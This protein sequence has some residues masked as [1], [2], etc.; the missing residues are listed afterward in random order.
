[1]ANSRKSPLPNKAVADL[2]DRFERALEAI[3]ARVVVSGDGALAVAC[4]GGLD[5]ALL[6]R[7]TAD[8]CRRTQRPLQVFHVH[9]G[10]SP[11]ADDWLSHCEA[12]AA[13]LGAGFDAVRVV[14]RDTRGDGIEQAAR[15]ARYDALGALCRRHG[16]KLLLTAH[17]QDDQAETVLLQLFRGA[18]LRG[19]S[20][21]AAMQ[22]APTLAGSGILLGRPLLDCRRAELEAVAV[23]LGVRHVVDESNADTRFR[24]NAVRHVILPVIARHFPAAGATIA[25]SSR[26]WQAAQRLLDE[27]AGIDEAHC[28]EG[29]ALRID[30]L[31]ALSVERVDNLLRHWL[32]GQGM[33]RPPNEAQ[34]AQLRQQVISAQADAHPALALAELT[35]QRHGGLLVALP[36]MDGWPPARELTI[37]WRGEAE[38][39]IPEWR[40]T[41]LFETADGA[42]ICPRR[43]RQERLCLRPRQGGERLKPEP[44]RPSRSLKNLFQEAAVPAQCRS[45]LPLVYLGGQLAFAAGLGMD[46]RVADSKGGVRL[47]WRPD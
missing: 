39:A 19:L 13:A 28:A 44:K 34:L 35:L 20:G 1:M 24:R 4:S 17:H 30:R 29:D 31:R 15:V 21:M 46:A 40:G 12:E 26:H 45:W 42:G 43:L 18:G 10:L 8:Y 37:G 9:H 5:S 16:V 6:L 32:A 3:L 38:M 25:R 41:L 47:G 33:R 23:A 27:L 2:T 22:E 14:L 11:H 7:L 36:R